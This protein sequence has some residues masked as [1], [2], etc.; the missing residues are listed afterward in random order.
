MNYNLNRTENIDTYLRKFN[1]NEF[2]NTIKII[3]KLH[4]QYRVGKDDFI[5]VTL[6]FDESFIA[7]AYFL[8]S[9]NIFH[10]ELGELWSEIG[11]NDYRKHIESSGMKKEWDSAK[12]VQNEISR[13][14]INSYSIN[15]HRRILT[16]INELSEIERSELS[17]LYHSD[18]IHHL[19]FYT[20]NNRCIACTES[21]VIYRDNFEL[22]SDA[23]FG[24]VNKNLLQNLQFQIDYSKLLT[25]SEFKQYLFQNRP[26]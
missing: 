20:S 9:G 24:L 23:I 25:H 14:I 18:A 7:D 22:A 26:R 5:W 8:L 12:K 2:I 1:L 16:L 10:K 19:V 6:D 15:E 13:N 17:R 21:N 11:T 4:Y 3:P